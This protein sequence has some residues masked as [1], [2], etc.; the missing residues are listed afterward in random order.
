MGAAAALAVL[1]STITAEAQPTRV[2][3]THVEAPAPARPTEADRQ[4]ASTA[5]G[6]ADQARKALE[7]ALKAQHGNKRDRWPADAQERL[8]DAEEA[9]DRANVDWLYRSQA[10][11]LDKSWAA[12]VA[13]ALTQSGRTGRK[14][15]VTSVASETEAQL[16]VTLTGLRN[17]MAATN[18]A[19]DRCLAFR[20]APGPKVSL[21]HFAR[22]PRS[23]R[24]RRAKAK[25]LDGPT[26]ASPAW[27]FEGCGLAPY[28]GEPEAVA[29]IVND[30]AGT[31]LAAPADPAGQ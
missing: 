20:V 9:R 6:V 19:A 23:Y 21:E 15:H 30:F 24:P 10:E 1:A 11:P 5:Y 28:F 22:V 18:A 3:V 31:L 17:P 29:N 13:R 26:G 7:K 25:R 8:A 27:R 12:D 14:E 16:I 4:A 2:F